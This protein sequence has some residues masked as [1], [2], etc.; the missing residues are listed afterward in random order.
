[1]LMGAICSKSGKTRKCT[2]RSVTV[3]GYRG[4]FK[5]SGRSTPF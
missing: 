2:K 5:T 3:E 1:M 4:H